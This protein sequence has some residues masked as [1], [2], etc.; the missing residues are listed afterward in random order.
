MFDVKYA[1]G[2][3]GAITLD[4]GAGV[5]VWPMD[6]QKEVQMMPK[7]K[8]LMMLAANGTEIENMGRN[9]VKFRGIAPVFKRRA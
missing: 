2:K 8:G 3:E 4:S 6:L 7:Q 5:N 9:M 1:D